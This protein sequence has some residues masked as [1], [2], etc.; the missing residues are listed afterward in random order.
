MLLRFAATLTLLALIAGCGPRS[1]SARR[2]RSQR[3]ADDADEAL[4]RAERAMADLDAP[5]AEGALADAKKVLADPD[6]QLYP[7]YEMLVSRAR[8][9]ESKLGD[10]RRAR[11]LKELQTA[12]G[13]AKDKVEE[14]AARLKKGLKALEAATVD[15]AATDEASDA[16]ADLQGALKDG[17]DYETKDK[18]YAE[19]A[20]KQRE[21]YE[22]AKDPLQ[23]ARA[24]LD[25]IDGPVALRDAALAKL[26]EGKAAKKP[27]DKRAAFEAAKKLYSD[28]QDA[29]RKAL[30]ASPAVSRLAIMAAGKKTTPEA[31]DT[32]CSAEWQDVDKLEAKIKPEKKKGKK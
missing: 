16:A 30:T 27:D 1:M 18:P 3:V 6:A 10:V 5:Q 23:L 8:E 7:E 13:K 24:R 22:K 15:K 32:A 12:I 25:F 11:E 9:A 14:Q 28:C 17:A 21:L 4:S 29:C 31:L 20:K 19:Y 2:E 26:K